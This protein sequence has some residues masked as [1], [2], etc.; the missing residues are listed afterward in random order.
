MRKS[1][2]RRASVCRSAARDTTTLSARTEVPALLAPAYGRVTTAARAP[3]AVSHA[4]LPS[5]CTHAAAVAACACLPPAESST[6]ARAH[7]A[8]ACLQPAPHG[9]LPTHRHLRRCALTAESAYRPVAAICARSDLAAGAPGAALGAPSACAQFRGCCLTRATE[10]ARKGPS[11]RALA[12]PSS[13]Q[14]THPRSH[15]PS[16]NPACAADNARLRP[17][18]HSLEG[19]RVPSGA[20]L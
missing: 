13:F 4:L 1:D 20:Y 10:N 19:Q 17:P 9:A 18:A 2:H 3:A 14:I 6:P 12:A 15:S 11:L 8:R 16:W 7:S 5:L